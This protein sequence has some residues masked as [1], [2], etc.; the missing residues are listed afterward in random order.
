MKLIQTKARQGSYLLL[1]GVL[2]TV[3]FWRLVIWGVEQ[4]LAVICLQEKWRLEP[5]SLYVK[6]MIIN[7]L[8]SVILQ[9]I[10][11]GV[12]TMVYLKKIGS[13]FRIKIGRKAA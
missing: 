11:S 4:F 5:F 12:V 7:L 9:M 1:L 2:I 13:D 8:F 6:Y 3:P 10:C